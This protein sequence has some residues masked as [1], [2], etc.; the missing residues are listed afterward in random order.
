MKDLNRI[1]I[2]ITQLTSNIET[3][4]PELYKYLEETPVTIPTEA[5]PH[6]DK[7]IL[8]DYL[9]SLKGLLRKHIESHTKKSKNEL[10]K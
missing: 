1:M 8:R 3:N 9:E 6:I 4:Y 5:H 7:E 2:E 10:H